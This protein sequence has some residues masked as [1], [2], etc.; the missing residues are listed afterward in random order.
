MPKMCGHDKGAINLCC[1]LAAVSCLWVDLSCLPFL[2]ASVRCFRGL[3]DSP[4]ALGALAQLFLTERQPGES[5]G[6]S[7]SVKKFEV[8]PLTNMP[9]GSPGCMSVRKKLGRQFQSLMSPVLCRNSWH[10]QDPSS[11]GKIHHPS[12]HS[13]NG[14]DSR[15]S[16]FHTIKWISCAR[17]YPSTVDLHHLAISVSNHSEMDTA[18][19]KR[20]PYIQAM[21]SAHQ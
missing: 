9:L 12:S 19:E 16:V 2:T 18:L 1:Y 3:R 21:V 14:Q 10:A 7:L 4:L 15:Q 8:S 17:T 13:I 11:P 5:Y 20:I 6:T